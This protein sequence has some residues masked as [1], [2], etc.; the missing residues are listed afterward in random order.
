MFLGSKCKELTFLCHP[1]RLLIDCIRLNWAPCAQ[2]RQ[3]CQK[4]RT[5]TSWSRALLTV[6][7]GKKLSICSHRHNNSP[8]DSVKGAQLGLTDSP[9][10]LRLLSRPQEIINSWWATSSQP[11]ICPICRLIEE[12][13]LP[14]FPKARAPFQ[15][16]SRQAPHWK[17]KN[18]TILTWITTT[19]SR[20]TL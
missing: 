10:T 1:E 9:S 5:W 17:P 19:S 4:C 8:Q 11:E 16:C 7:T 15:I 6:E 13:K 12:W 14:V 2:V 20:N 3:M 18:K